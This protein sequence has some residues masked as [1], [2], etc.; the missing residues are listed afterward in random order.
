MSAR[1]VLLAA[2]VLL[3]C[4]AAAQDFAVVGATLAI[5][6]GS[7][8]IPNGT[9]VVRGGKVVAAGAGIAVP[10]GIQ[11]IDARGKWVT[12]G[13]VV[14]VTDLGLLDVEAVARSN[15]SEANKAVFNAA[16]DVA[17]A[18][19]PEA[20]HIQVSRA[21]GVTRAAVAPGAGNAIFAGQG[22]VIDL[23]ADP[24]PVT[25]PRAFQYVELGEAG[26]DL[27]GGS[28]AAT[29]AVLHNAL[30][31]AKELAASP[32][33]GRRDDVLLTRRDA[34]ALMPVVSGQQP[35]YVHVERAADI[36]LALGLRR[37]FP[38]LKLVIVGATEGWRVAGELAASGVPVLATPLNDLPA[39][40]EELAATQSNV[41]RLMKAGVKVSLG[42]FFDQP[43]YA[44][45]YAGNLV[46]LSKLPGA[47][48]LTWGQAFAAISS[49]PAEAMG[50]ADRFGSLRVGRA[51]DVVIWDG[52]PLEASSG[53][54]RVFIDGIE[55]PLSNHQTRLR[56]RYRSPTEGALPK[57]YDW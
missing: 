56:D 18:I 26:S 34:A 16:L 39:Q 32:A 57:A 47:S 19:N 24:D 1:H 31:E 7:A 45:Q 41:G 51:G 46:A 53:V 36:R 40:F 12:P 11:T 54:L 6:D 5:G 23:G 22:A 20:Q 25:K 50:M 14:A 29:Y 28:R 35:L 9:V 38:A 15:D 49:G 2:A 3:A 27:A 44:P 10:T 17:P 52:D 30:S 4:P 42:A 33:G 21:G 37:E 55:Q 43:R 8:P 13:L 48:G